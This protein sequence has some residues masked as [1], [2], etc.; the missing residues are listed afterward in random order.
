MALTENDFFAPVSDLAARIRTR[1]LSP[2]EL[3]EGYLARIERQNDRFNA[4]ATVTRPP[5]TYAGGTT[6]CLRQSCTRQ[7]WAARSP[8]GRSW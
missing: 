5:N 1:M 8:T 4:Y 6:R 2:V 7:C 3:T